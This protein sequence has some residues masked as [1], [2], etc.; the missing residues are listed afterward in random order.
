[1][2]DFLWMLK[3][4]SERRWKI[5]EE[6]ILID[7]KRAGVKNVYRAKRAITERRSRYNFYIRQF[8]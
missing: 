8:T 5:R 7:A 6:A 4:I 3:P 1:M 2:S